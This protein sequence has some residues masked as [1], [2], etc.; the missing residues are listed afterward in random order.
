MLAKENRQ[1][2]FCASIN[3]GDEETRKAGGSAEK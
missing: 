2:A 1:R 3:R